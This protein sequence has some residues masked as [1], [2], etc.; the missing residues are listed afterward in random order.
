MV[1]PIRPRAT[2]IK[3]HYRDVIREIMSEHEVRPLPW[4]RPC[5][6]LSPNTDLRE[7][8]QYAD[9][10]VAGRGDSQPHH[11][12]QR[13]LVRL[14]RYRASGRR[15]AHVDIG[16]GT[17]L[18]SW[19]FL[20]WATERGITFDSLELYGYDDHCQ[21]MID[22]AEMA[23][24]KLATTIA[25][26]PVMHYYSDA[27]LLLRRL[28]Q[29]HQ[30]ATDYIVTFGYVLIQA[31]SPENIR[32]FASILAHI[33]RLPE[34]NSALMT[35]DAYSGNRSA[36]SAAAKESLWDCL[37]QMGIS[38]RRHNPRLENPRHKAMT[39]QLSFIWY[40]F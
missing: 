39:A 37:K 34:S 27:D 10:Y 14:R 5:Y 1:A 3:D 9:W 28:T 19:A 11:R 31:N 32:E 30:N 21:A 6:E 4:G 7:V 16:C 22:V 12:Y 2:Y 13:Y 25:N 35:V 20:D 29:T 40:G 15:L 23:R 8:L 36:L 18:F 38:G 24:A 33:A 26:F 17:G